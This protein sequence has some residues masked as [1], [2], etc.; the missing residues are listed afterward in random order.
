M[1]KTNTSLVK[2]LTKAEVFSIFIYN[3]KNILQMKA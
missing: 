2:G 3:V 1:P